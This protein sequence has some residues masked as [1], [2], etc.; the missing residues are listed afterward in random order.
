MEIIYMNRY[1]KN[2][3]GN[4]KFAKV[5]I[6]ELAG[7][8]TVS[9]T[10]IISDDQAELNEW[11]SG[12][13]LEQAI[14]TLKHEQALKWEIGY[15]PV[16][17]DFAGVAEKS[18]NQLRALMLDYYSESHADEALFHALKEWRLKRSKAEKKA[19][20]LIATNR[21][22]RMVA[23]Y[24]PQS[25]EELLELPGF[26]KQRSMQ[27][28]TEIC[29]LTK[30]LNQPRPFPL[31][32][33]KA[34]IDESA[35]EAWAIRQR[36]EK[37]KREIDADVRRKNMLIAVSTLQTFPDL[38]ATCNVNLRDGAQLLEDLERDGYNL[39]AWLDMQWDCF[40]DQLIG[41]E[42]ALEGFE[43]LGD[44]FLKPV[45]TRQFTEKEL[46]SKNQDELYAWLRVVRL[47]YRST[48][49]QAVA[50]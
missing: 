21:M 39:N 25:R 15:R 19:P 1:V 28:A 35:F 38:C 50:A 3:D 2:E 32:W 44:R 23:T 14:R 11:Y 46:S 26:G 47:Y 31:D 42:A 30:E 17:A 10:A 36:E 7:K 5:A 40:P 18:E 6:Q 22:L 45:L 8:W 27:L 24:F 29:L 37:T 16:V 20:Y 41:K 48:L 34:E 49:D 13:D 9:W 4:K 12:D 33:V 43:E